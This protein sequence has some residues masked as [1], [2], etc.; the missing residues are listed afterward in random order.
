M[1]EITDDTYVL[2]LWFV[3]GDNRDW[4]GAVT[5]KRG[6]EVFEIRYRFRYYASLDPFDTNDRKNWYMATLKPG[7][8]E[9][10]VIQNM[11]MM[12]RVMTLGPGFFP[13]V[14]FGIVRDYG[15][16]PFAKVL[17]AKS[18]MSTRM[19]GE[20]GNYNGRKS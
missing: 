5:R 15:M 17:G 13:E 7:I 4:M 11:H 2:G 1:I 6:E 8:S 16:E 3:A 9:E 18:W 20:L 19:E 12:A 10:E 14:D